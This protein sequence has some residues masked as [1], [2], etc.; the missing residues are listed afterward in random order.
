VCECVCVQ[1]CPSSPPPDAF[2]LTPLPPHGA[3]KDS[4]ALNFQWTPAQNFVSATATATVNNAFNAYDNCWQV[5]T[6][7]R[8]GCGDIVNNGYSAFAASCAF[9]VFIMVSSGFL[10]VYSFFVLSWGGPPE[11]PWGVM[12]GT[13]N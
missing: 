3:L 7:A 10:C 5:N 1:R 12:G 2:P 9:C 6:G 13:V 4:R 11:T 8:Y